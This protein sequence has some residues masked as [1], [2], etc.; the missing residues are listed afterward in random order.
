MAAPRNR[1]SLISLAAAQV[2]RLLPRTR[3]SNAVG[4]LCDRP[5]SPTVANWVTKSYSA[6]Y[7]VD[8][9]EAERGV[10]PYESF[11]DFF[12]R[13]LRP[14]ARPIDDAKLVSPADGNLVAA[15]P[16]DADASFMVKD[17]PYS[18]ADLVGDSEDA[19][20]YVG[21]DYSLTYLSPR[22]YHRV[23]CPVDGV[24]S[25][26]RSMPGD[27]YPVNSIGERHVEGLFARNLRVAV[28]I[29]TKSMGRV[30]LVLVGA[31]I[32]GR[33]SISAVP[34]PSVPLGEHPVHP[35]LTVSRGAEVGQFHLGS[36]TVLFTEPGSGVTRRPG[37]VRLGQ[38]LVGVV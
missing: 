24:I 33:I 2:L 13:K 28:C 37:P 31:F 10:G 20:R 36:S 7:D 18:V 3:I 12:T 26:V 4:Q 15:G 27:L 23:H 9:E 30:T 11:D 21:G 35:G 5:L 25:L 14:G 32:V 1:V 19:K 34:G 29:E 16:V 22:D 38:S 17:S 6:M 8:V